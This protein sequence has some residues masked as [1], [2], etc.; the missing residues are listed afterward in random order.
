MPV[1]PSGFTDDAGGESYPVAF[2]GWCEMRLESFRAD[3]KSD[4]TWFLL[5]W[6]DG[7]GRRASTSLNLFVRPEEAGKK[8]ANEISLGVLRG[9][10]RAAGLQEADFP[11][12]SAREIVKALN[13]Y[14]GSLTVDAY[15]APD[16]KEFLNAN[17]FRKASGAKPKDDEVGF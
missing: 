14:E 10:W 15:C 8:K 4:R 16:D 3:A 2:K 5:K 9:L 1:D 11:A 12:P 13:G 6:A 17:K 7:D